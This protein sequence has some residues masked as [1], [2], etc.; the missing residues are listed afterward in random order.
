MKIAL[1]DYQLEL[2]TEA[3]HYNI[4]LEL[5]DYDWDTLEEELSTWEDLLERAREYNVEPATGEY[6]PVALKQALEDVDR[7]I[8]REMMDANVEYDDGRGLV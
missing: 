4:P 6:D 1:T 5:T 7:G 3:I 2:L 8:H